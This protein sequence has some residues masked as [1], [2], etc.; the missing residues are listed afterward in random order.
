MATACTPRARFAK[1]FDRD[2]LAALLSTVAELDGVLDFGN[3]L[4]SERSFFTALFLSMQSGL[5]VPQL[6]A[7][8]WRVIRPTGEIPLAVQLDREALLAVGRIVSPQRQ[9]VFATPDGY[10]FR[11]R[12]A[13]I[14]E[15]AGW[16]IEKGGDR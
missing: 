13:L 4:V 12:L 1:P 2:R 11:G 8:H 9:Q 15:W 7:L 3:E 16:E 10:D 14:R 5:S 6:R